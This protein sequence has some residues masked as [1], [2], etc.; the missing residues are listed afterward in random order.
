MNRRDAFF[1]GSL[2]LSL[3]ALL[4]PF[5]RL[6]VDL[7]HDGVMLKPALD[8]LSGQTLFRDTF[9]QYGALTCYL[10]VVALWFQPTL[11]SIRLLTVAAYGVTLFFLYASWRL[12]LPRSLTILACA[13]FILFIP[14]YEQDWL[15]KYWLLL[16]WSS[17]FALMFQ[18]V[19]LYALFRVIRDESPGQ[20]GLVLG[21]ACAGV[22]WCRQPVGVMMFGSI[23][24][25]WLGLHWTNWAPANRSKRSILV[26]IIGGFVAVNA[27]FLSSILISGAVPEW[28][29]QNFIWPRKWMLDDTQV[30]S[31]AIFQLYVHLAAGAGLLALL[32]AAA[33]PALLR[34][35]RPNLSGRSITIYYFCLAGVLLW[36]HERVLQLLALREGG[37]TA[38]FPFV[39]LLQVVSSIMLW[40]TRRHQPTITESH[41]IAALAV[42]SLGAL[43]QYY[44]VADPWHI[45]WA[46][47]P[48]FGLVVRV[49]WQWVGGPA[50]AVAIALTIAF[51]PAVWARAQSTAR[52]LA[53]PGVTLDRPPI[54][55]GMKVPPEQARR[56][57]L[58]TDS[59]DQIL[60][61][62]PDIPSALFGN[63]PLYLCF[64]N[65]HFN[66][67]PYYVTWIGLSD[68]EAQQQRWNQI[69]R[70]RPLIFL[71]Q[72]KW[73][74]VD[75]F[76]RRSGY[77]PMLYIAEENLEIAVPRELADKMGR[78]AY[79]AR[80]SGTENKTL[81]P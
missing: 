13:L 41:L 20:W 67:S 59:L 70:V 30:N 51:L 45:F 58:V 40:V 18:S 44:P 79:G 19:G 3:V 71:H 31:K 73:G 56:L 26:A 4:V 9:S 81:K 37:W 32:M 77:I 76:Y 62:Q 25:V 35:F 24:V 33:L 68:Q 52:A 46:L 28:W 47:A 69:Q 16:P 66:V 54:L 43:P 29:Y 12:I 10:Q 60:R 38:L 17:V 72:A 22:F 65:N 34:R 55:H 1:A 78:S 74:A 6:G 23:A 64:T 8:V 11:L 75:D 50:L 2:S 39:V 57:G 63:D 21:L 15:N 14:S 53:R 27:V 49:V 42:V 61:Y 80:S 7:H 48:A 36:Q 5:A